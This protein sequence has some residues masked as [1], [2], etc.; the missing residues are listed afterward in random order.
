MNEVLAGTIAGV[1]ATVAGAVLLDL[2]RT[3]WSDR[4]RVHRIR[5]VRDEWVEALLELYGRKFTDGNDY[6]LDE[7]RPCM[8]QKLSPPRPVPVENITLIAIYHEEIVGFVMCHY[9]PTR[10]KGIISYLAAHHATAALQKRAGVRLARAMKR[11]LLRQRCEM[12][13]YE[14]EL[15]TEHKRT[16][17]RGPRPGLPTLLQQRV[18]ITGL[19]ARQLCF[20]YLCPKV[21]LRAVEDASKRFALY[22]VSVRGPLP[23][24]L[25]R[26]AVQEYLR[27]I[28][29]DCYGDLYSPEDSEYSAHQTAL[30]RSLAEQ[31]RSLPEAIDLH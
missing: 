15:P 9:Y 30:T 14:V 28:Y 6:D 22:C 24:A 2:L 8:D 18:E 10:K 3:H 23:K 1:A 19:V 29:L 21:S 27:F 20:P 17:P 4:I 26:D 16:R 31:T 7:I 13:F 12:I 25:S 11:I 5:R